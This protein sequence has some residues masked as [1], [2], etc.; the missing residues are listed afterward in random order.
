MEAVNLV[1]ASL[2]IA[3]TTAILLR[4]RES[5]KSVSV[6]SDNE[7]VYRAAI[8]PDKLISAPQNVSTMYES[9]M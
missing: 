6:V 4:R 1:Y 8:C 5:K 7:N 3:L 9:F 2:A